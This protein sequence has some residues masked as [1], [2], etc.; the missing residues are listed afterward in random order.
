MTSYYYD[1]HVHSCLSPCAD[2]DMTPNN[3][4]GMAALKG[5]QILALTDHNSCKNCPAFFEACRRQ[6]I[7]PIAG[8]ELSTAEDIHLV[9]LFES[10]EQAM[11]FDK[12]IETHRMQIPNR[13]EIFGNQLILDGEDELLGTEEMLL[14]AATDLPIADAIDLARAYGAHVHPAHIDREA[15]GI[16]AV[17]GGIPEEYSF[18]SFE[19]REAE[20]LEEMLTRF[21]R[22]RREAVLVSSDAHRLWEI[23]EAENSISLEDE[24]YSSSLVRQRFFEY[25][26]DLAK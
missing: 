3:I 4:A 7:I 15:N 16:V 6:G 14:I 18:S 24:P 5:L 21:P 17:L 1:L 25:L 9:C 13:P 2:D 22:I 19:L 8:M 23:N 11:T 20:M 10:L 12:V 26:K